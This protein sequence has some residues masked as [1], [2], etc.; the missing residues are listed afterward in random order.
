MDDCH[1]GYR[2]KFHKKLLTIIWKQRF[3]LL[4]MRKH[5]IT[6]YDPSTNILPLSREA[7]SSSIQ[8]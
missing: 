6:S 4:F 5:T 8:V 3:P 1:V 7:N 2:L